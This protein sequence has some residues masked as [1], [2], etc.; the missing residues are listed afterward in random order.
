MKALIVIFA[1]L[2]FFSPYDILPD[3]LGPL[4]R[5]DDILVAFLSYWLYQSRRR[6]QWQAQKHAEFGAGSAYRPNSESARQGSET[7]SATNEARRQPPDPYTTLELSPPT[8]WEEIETQYKKLMAQY[9]PDKVHH[10]G[11]ELRQLAHKK[12]IEI[13]KAYQ[14]LKKKFN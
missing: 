6:L 1:L 7:S 13:G 5:L 4:G 9:H 12:S 11:P 14:E 10:L 8:S 3:F 2:Y